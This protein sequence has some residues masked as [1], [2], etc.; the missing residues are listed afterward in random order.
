MRPHL[1]QHPIRVDL[2]RLLVVVVALAVSTSVLVIRSEAAFTA[3]VGN[4][5]NE[6]ASGQVKLTDN[7]I[8]SAMFLLGE[9]DDHLVPG[10]VQRRCI[11][12]KYSGTVGS[13]KLSNVRL[14]VT[15]TGDLAPYLVTSVE[16][17]TEGSEIFS[18][19]D[20]AS[21]DGFGGTVVDVYNDATTPN[22]SLDLAALAGTNNTYATGLNTT[23][24][25]DRGEQRWFRISFEVK[26][27]DAAQ[28][29]T[30]SPTFTWEIRTEA[31]N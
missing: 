26:P 19:D 14:Y 4:A 8:P 21:C 10:E 12:I 31:P 1:R 18:K 28:L 2:L 22:H 30:A 3:S 23:W 25:P 29:R 15:S 24:R 17:G 7:A 16:M 5:G 9:M 20:P 6:L 13:D 11:Q 27:D